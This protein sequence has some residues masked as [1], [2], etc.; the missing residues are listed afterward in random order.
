M[1][2]LESLLRQVVLQKP[3]LIPSSRLAV[4]LRAELTPGEEVRGKVLAR[5]SPGQFL[6]EIQGKEVTARSSF[7]PRVGSEISLRVE[8]LFPEI[9]LSL[10]GES[11]PLGV[12]A[13]GAALSAA[14]ARWREYAGLWEEVVRA[15]GS[16][17]EEGLRAPEAH[18]LEAVLTGLVLDSPSASALQKAVEDGGQFYEAAL[19]QAARDGVLGPETAAADLKGALLRYLG[20]VHSGE[21]EDGKSAGGKSGLA[22]AEPARRLLEVI[23][24]FQLSNAS[25][26]DHP[27]FLSIPLALGLPGSLS[28]AYLRVGVPRKGTRR[29][30][31]GPFSLLLYLRMSLLGEVRIDGLVAGRRIKIA[32]GVNSEDAASLL[33]EGERFLRARLAQ[34]DFH[35]AEYTCRVDPPGVEAAAGEVLPLELPADVRLLDLRI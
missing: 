8:A 15:L 22:A 29:Q 23:E 18:K 1:N 25:R 10:R 3:S 32:V 16:A 9:V 34:S 33:R 7:L 31:P 35:L 2:L 26:E 30:K 11:L 12:P 14:L 17:P 5:L 24:L 21:G 27:G 4:D 6:V 20:A 28:G 13:G 19:L